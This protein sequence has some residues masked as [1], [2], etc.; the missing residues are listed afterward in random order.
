MNVAP[1]FF[2]LG[3]FLGMVFGI[4]IFIRLQ[5]QIHERRLPSTI[6]WKP[7]VGKALKGRAVYDFLGLVVAVIVINIALHFLR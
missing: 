5:Q 6:S 3:I 4:R 1:F 2:F 7:L